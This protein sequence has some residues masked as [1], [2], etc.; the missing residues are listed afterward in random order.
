[1]YTLYKDS[2]NNDKRVMILLLI[3]VIYAELKLFK[4]YIN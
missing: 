1:M 2:I 3:L 4:D